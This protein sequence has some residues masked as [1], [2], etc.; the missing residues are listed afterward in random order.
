MQSHPPTPQ[1]VFTDERLLISSCFQD[2]LLFGKLYNKFGSQS[3]N[4]VCTHVLGKICLISR[5]E[6]ISLQ[7]SNSLERFFLFFL[8]Q[9]LGLVICTQFRRKLN[10]TGSFCPTVPFP[11]CFQI[12][13]V[14]TLNLKFF[15]L[16]PRVGSRLSRMR[17]SHPAKTDSEE[18]NFIEFQ[19]H[20]SAAG[21]REGESIK[22]GM[23]RLQ[24]SLLS[25]HQKGNPFLSCGSFGGWE[26]AKVLSTELKAQESHSLRFC[27]KS[28]DVSYASAKIYTAVGLGKQYKYQHST[29]LFLRQ[30]F[31]LIST[32]FSFVCV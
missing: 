15:A 24:T 12:R 18:C 30:T 27:G 6:L 20:V 9:S 7:F 17:I 32:V 10:S 4:F 1:I 5:L 13:L 31:L 11:Q 14:I 2:A 19:F 25:P 23:R 21:E 26:K 28:L 29:V 16:S 3:K 22:S 8:A